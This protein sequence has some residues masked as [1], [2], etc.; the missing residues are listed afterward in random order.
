MTLSLSLSLSLCLSRNPVFLNEHRYC[1][2]YVL[3]LE[4]FSGESQESRTP[5]KNSGDTS[6]EV[7]GH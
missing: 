4:L 2:H 6:A 1:F 3:C 7:V 5:T